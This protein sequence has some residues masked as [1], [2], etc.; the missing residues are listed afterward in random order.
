VFFSA[1]RFRSTLFGNPGPFDIDFPLSRLPA[2]DGCPDTDFYT[3]DVN[4]MC[5]SCPAKDDTLAL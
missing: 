1:L 2:M 4:K 3:D 5:Y